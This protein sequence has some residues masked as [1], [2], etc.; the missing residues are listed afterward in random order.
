MIM[1]CFILV[2]IYQMTKKNYETSSLAVMRNIAMR[3]VRDKM[4]DGQEKDIRIPYFTLQINGQGQ[5]NARGSSYYDLS[6]RDFL[7]ELVDMT[8][9]R[10][11]NFGV[12]EEYDL[13]YY[14]TENPKGTCLVFVDISSE[15]ATLDHLMKTSALIVLL[16]FFI[17]LAISFFLANW[18]IRPVKTAWEQQ[19]QFVADASHELKTPPDRS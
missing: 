7:Q 5:I 10:K 9:S 4:P 12:I 2:L 15:R 3:P 1:L 19:R 18:A 6:D 8:D 11:E 17:F 16:S 13:R 14:R